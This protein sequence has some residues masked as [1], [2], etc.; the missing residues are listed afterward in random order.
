MEILNLEDHIEYVKELISGLLKDHDLEAL[1]KA[2]TQFNK[3]TLVMD[4]E[5]YRNPLESVDDMLYLLTMWKTIENNNNVSL[6]SSDHYDVYNTKSIWHILDDE[7][8]C[9]ES[10]DETFSDIDSHYVRNKTYAYISMHNWEKI[11]ACQNFCTCIFRPEMA[12][13]VRLQYFCPITLTNQYIETACSGTTD[14][15]K[16]S[17]LLTAKLEDKEYE[18]KNL[19]YYLK[20]VFEE[21]EKK[22]Y[23]ICKYEI[24]TIADHIKHG[25]AFIF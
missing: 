12:Y 25:I 7:D 17:Q 9:V 3:D 15:L 6:C 2:M 19:D 14:A 1:Y 8:W 4:D 11:Q 21:I 24:C 23:E 16:Y 22:S 20:H 10:P 18:S 13:N 5:F